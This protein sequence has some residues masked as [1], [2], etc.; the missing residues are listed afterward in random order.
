MSGWYEVVYQGRL[1][2]DIDAIQVGKW[3]VCYQVKVADAVVWRAGE[4]TLY[5]G[6]SSGLWERV[7]PRIRW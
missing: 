3:S 6:F 5:W 1:L 7:Y 4:L 2:T